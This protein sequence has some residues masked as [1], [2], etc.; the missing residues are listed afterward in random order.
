MS[1]DN[2]GDDENADHSDDSCKTA[3]S[4]EDVR[5]VCSGTKTKRRNRRL[6]R[7]PTDAKSGCRGAER[8]TT[9]SQRELASDSQRSGWNEC[10]GRSGEGSQRD[11]RLSVDELDGGAVCSGYR[12]ACTDASQSGGTTTADLWHVESSESKLRCDKEPQFLSKTLMPPQRGHSSPMVD[13][14]VSSRSGKISAST[15]CP[16]GF[17]S[18]SSIRSAS[19]NDEVPKP[20]SR[21]YHPR[22][23]RHSTPCDFIRPS[24]DDSESHRRLMQGSCRDLAQNSIACSSSA[25]CSEV[26]DE[27]SSMFGFPTK[28]AS[29]NSSAGSQALRHRYLQTS[30]E[31]QNPGS[32]VKVAQEIMSSTD[33]PCEAFN[34]ADVADHPSP[35]LAVHD[36]RHS[37]TDRPVRSF[38][39]ADVADSSLVG[40][41]ISRHSSTDRP[42]TSFN[43]ADLV[44]SFP[45]ESSVHHSRRLSASSTAASRHFDDHSAPPVVSRRQWNHFYSDCEEC[46]H[47]LS[48]ALC[49]AC[50]TIHE[51]QHDADDCLPPVSDLCERDFLTGSDGSDPAARDRYR[52]SSRNTGTVDDGEFLDRLTA[53][54]SA[55]NMDLHAFI[56]RE[57]ATAENGRGSSE[58]PVG[59]GLCSRW[60]HDEGQSAKRD[61]TYKRFRSLHFYTDCA[62]CPD[63][64]SSSLCGSCCSVHG[65]PVEPADI[66]PRC[67]KRRRDDDSRPEDIRLVDSHDPCRKL[68]SG[69]DSKTQTSTSDDARAVPDDSAATENGAN[70][71]DSAAGNKPSTEN[72]ASTDANNFAVSKDSHIDAGAHRPIEFSTA[73]STGTSPDKAQMTSS[74]DATDEECWTFV[75]KATCSVLVLLIFIVF[76]AIYLQLTRRYFTGVRGGV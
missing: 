16:F 61:T 62:D 7:R 66:S 23:Y 29:N 74:G 45:V 59:L 47:C 18:L 44:D 42:A 22:K 30:S 20:D 72:K 13:T 36:S 9:G 14:A 73:E 21:E 34:K 41:R 65:P 53:R 5:F 56:D 17:L 2:D 6:R 46:P 48:Y 70:N 27:V 43:S 64:C 54:S 57:T 67:A 68:P 31:Q 19:T 49:A 15:R 39:G 60:C 55:Q 50:N 4:R 35:E 1:D 37:S 75:E 58:A 12:Q 76:S 8:N 33:W 10:T 69:G 3:G 38:V 51:P 71:T 24:R 11:R 28:G 52:Y 40:S 26:R 32:V 25:S 63:C